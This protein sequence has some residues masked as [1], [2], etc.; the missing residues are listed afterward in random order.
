MKSIKTKLTLSFFILIVTITSV[1]GGIFLFKGYR[2]LEEEAEKS[3]LL[4]ATESSQ[5]VECKMETLIATLTVIAKNQDIVNMG[6]EVDVNILKEE[7]RKTSFLDLGFVLPNGYATYTSGTVSLMSDRSYVKS[8]L[9]GTAMMSD[10]IISRVTR[11]P[12]IE[13]CVPVVKDGEVVGALVARSEANTL[14]KLTE[15]DG[16]GES[17]YAFMI[18][19]DGRIIAYPD[20]T[21][22]KE[23]YNPIMKAEEDKKLQ[24]LA[25]AFQEMLNQKSG[26]TSYEQDGIL[27][28]AGYAPVAGTNW[29]CAITAD[30]REVFAVIPGMIRT[31]VIVMVLVVVLSMGIVYLLDNTITTPLRK[32]TAVSKK[33]AEL[34]FREDISE[35]YLKQKDEIGT[36]SRTFQTLT[37]QL[38][39]MISYINE[40]ANQVSASAQELT[41][42][43]VQ[44]AQIS[45][46]ISSAVDNI[47]KGATE[48]ADNTQAGT[49]NAAILG[50][51]IESNHKHVKGLNKA[52]K[53]VNDLVSSGLIDVEHLASAA[54]QNKEATDEICDI[55]MQTKKSS[56]LIGEASKMISDMARQTNLLAL[57]ASIEAARAGD[58]GRGFS[59]VAEEI[60]RM[61][62]QSAA[63]TKHIDEIINTLIHNVKKSEGSM[64]RIR[65]TSQEQQR[66]VNETIQK[67]Q[68]IATSMETSEEAATKLNESEK[69]MDD[70]KNV[71]VD[72]LYSLS[73]IAQQN[74]AGTQQAASFVEEQTVSAKTLAETSNK[75]T[76]LALN[77]Q[78][79]VERFKL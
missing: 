62:D 33:I 72:M 48:Q 21:V 56:E 28:L 40:S 79:T 67:Y 54:K 4:I 15:E 9:S 73:A 46:E 57:N 76:D 41:A 47:A 64:I 50:Q 1:M 18:N 63:S 60:T 61:A 38:R 20:E 35:K 52:T 75:L 55:V 39:E 44:S 22:V 30:E 17:G 31:I 71:I 65:E 2:S 11:R 68:A 69:D 78:N 26:I 12:E 51:I 32:I 66:Q 13:I 45:L 42:T 7:L 27:Y 70:A 53:Q 19:A 36:L 16:Y 6:W 23:N 8:A 74:A 29:I 3:L 25:K 14:S 77:L 10:V 43:S 34:D 5:N 37:Q 49:E 59:V 24:S 58:A